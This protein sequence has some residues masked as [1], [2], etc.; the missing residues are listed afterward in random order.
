MVQCSIAPAGAGGGSVAAQLAAHEGLVRWVVRQQRRGPLAYADALQEGRLGLWRALR[1]YDPTRGTRFS[2]Y[3]VPAIRH[4]V[5]AAVAQARAAE[6]SSPPA[7]GP[8]MAWD[9]PV[10][11]L[12]AAEV[13]AALRVLVDQLPT[14]LRRV[15]VAHYGLGPKPAQ[16]LAA[17]G[18]RLGVSRQ[19]VHQLKAEALVWLAQP[20]H[21][22]ALRRLVGRQGRADYQQALARQRQGARA[23]RGG[24]R[25]RRWAW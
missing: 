12:A 9:D 24:G 6:P 11:G 8:L 19:R 25:R 17:I 7:A 22:R 14:G 1:G 18:R 16:S 20:D 15:I 5:W 23:R 2:T 13:A 3:A 10:E 21:S 4:A